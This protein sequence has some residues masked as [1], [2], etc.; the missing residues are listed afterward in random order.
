M[1][2]EIHRFNL[3][4]G[5][6]SK[7]LGIEVFVSH[8]PQPTPRLLSYP[9]E[10]WKSLPNKVRDLLG[11]MVDVNLQRESD[12]DLIEIVVEPYPYP[13]SYRGAYHYRSGA[14]KQEFKGE[15][16]DLFLLRKQGRIT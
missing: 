9:P 4:R 3:P 12:K 16:L 1:Q 13:I 10:T 15:A 6:N 14:T 8:A 2:P 7:N 5:T 11:I